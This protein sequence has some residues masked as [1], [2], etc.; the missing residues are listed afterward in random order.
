ME[1]GFVKAAVLYAAK[2][3]AL[4]PGDLVS[5]NGEILI[6]HGTHTQKG[7]VNVEFKVPAKNGKKSASLKKLKIVKTLT[8]IHSTWKK[9]SQTTKKA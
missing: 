7:N 6:V 3:V 8:P 4:N 1:K 5:L 9:V 2:K